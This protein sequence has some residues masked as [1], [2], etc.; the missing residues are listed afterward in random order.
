MAQSFRRLG[1]RV[2]EAAHAEE[3]TIL[4][5]FELP[6]V[7]VTDEELPTLAQLLEAVRSTGPLQGIPVTIINPDEE[8]GTRCG[9]VL[10]LPNHRA[11]QSVLNSTRE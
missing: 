8:E 2:V 6:D 11:I 4:G 1:Y 10:L 7:I 3:A 5:G 9:E